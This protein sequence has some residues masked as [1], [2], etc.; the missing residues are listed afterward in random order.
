MKSKITNLILVAAFFLE[1]MNANAQTQLLGTTFLGGSHGYGTIF[2][3]NEDG[4]GYSVVY[5]FDSVSGFKP[6]DKMTKASNGKCYGIC[7]RGG[8]SNFGVIY[9]FDPTSNTYAVIH[10]FDSVSGAAP[11]TGLVQAA[12]DLLY[13]V[14]QEG[15]VNN[16]CCGI[17]YSI[18]PATNSYSILHN[19]NDT[20]NI[21]T[22]GW[23]PTGS[24]LCLNNKLYGMTTAGGLNDDGLIYCYDTNSNTFTDIHDF[25]NSHGQAGAGL[26]ALGNDGK[27]YGMAS[28]GGAPNYYGVIFSLDTSNYT[29]TS[30]HNFDQVNG[31]NPAYSCGMIKATNGILYG[32]AVQ[33]GINNEGVL[34]SFNPTNNTFTNIHNFDSTA[35]G[36]MTLW[37][38]MQ[39][40]N[41]KLYG[42]AGLGGTNNFGTIFS[43]DITGNI[44]SVIHNFD[45]INGDSPRGVL[46]ELNTSREGIPGINQA[47]GIS[48]YPNPTTTLLHIHQ[49]IPSPNQQLIIT[50]LLGTEV[51]KEMLTGID[52]T[53]SISTWSAGI[54]FYEIRNNNGIARGKIIVQR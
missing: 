52:N 33:G 39:G 31:S 50:D 15:P 30:L 18:D 41:G 51:Y 54:Y 37:D 13:G 43:Y 34:F 1:V 11:Y 7:F 17:L 21:N 6:L 45:S 40:S 9:S 3:V 25:D 48:I 2:K 22:T 49:S 53:I 16:A 26:L 46:L 42:C 36:C 19:F 24:P 23:L 44:Y 27:L 32:M 38:L 5:N 20:N 8:S 4:T 35:G 12:N 14:V 10:E 28:L 29:F 47:N